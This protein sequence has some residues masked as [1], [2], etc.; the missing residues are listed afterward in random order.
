MDTLGHACWVLRQQSY[1]IMKAL[2]SFEREKAEE[3]RYLL[4]ILQPVYC[5]AELYFLATVEGT[6]TLVV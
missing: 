3:L 6:C 4:C 5:L 2:G 1:D